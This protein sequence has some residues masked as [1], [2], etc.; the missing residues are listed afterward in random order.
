MVQQM[1]MVGYEGNWI[2]TAELNSVHWLRKG[3]QQSDLHN[4]FVLHVKGTTETFVG[5][6]E[7]MTTMSNIGKRS[8]LTGYSTTARVRIIILVALAGE[9]QVQRDK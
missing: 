7:V 2:K 9:T 8:V 1:G 6:T 3:K 5:T 4:S